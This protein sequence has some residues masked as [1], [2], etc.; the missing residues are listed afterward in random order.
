MNTT[1]NDSLQLTGLPVTS[2][3][4][5]KVTLGKPAAEPGR[6]NLSNKRK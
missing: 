4:I 6:Y 1:H 2:F 5:A 3:A